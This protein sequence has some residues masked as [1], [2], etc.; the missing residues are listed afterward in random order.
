MK[1]TTQVASDTGDA[2]TRFVPDIPPPIAAT[3]TPEFV[4]PGEAAAH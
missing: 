1:E 4:F 3:R 2:G